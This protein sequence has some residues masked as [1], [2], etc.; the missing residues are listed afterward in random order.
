MIK[1]S[2]K[3]LDSSLCLGV[4]EPPERKDDNTF[5]A[6]EFTSSSDKIQ[7]C[8]HQIHNKSTFP[9]KDSTKRRSCQRCMR[10]SSTK[11]AT[12]YLLLR[13]MAS[14]QWFQSRWRK[15]QDIFR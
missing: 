12:V 9:R 7:A 4:S 3:T 1:S 13:A 10:N 14:N 6:W 8:R 11:P 15:T 5:S 2:L